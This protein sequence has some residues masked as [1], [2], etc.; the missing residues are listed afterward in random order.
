MLTQQKTALSSQTLPLNIRPSRDPVEDNRESAIQNESVDNSYRNS[1]VNPPAK[2]ENGSGDFQNAVQNESYVKKDS[3]KPSLVKKGAN[4][5][6]FQKYVKL[7]GVR[8]N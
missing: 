1:L 4:E 7:K 3:R 8:P 2:L 5:I 6:I